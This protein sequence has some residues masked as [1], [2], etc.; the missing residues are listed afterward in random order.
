ME[1]WNSET[2]R[3]ILTLLAPMWG[4]LTL[5]PIAY[6]IEQHLKDE[7][8]RPQIRD[9]GGNFTFLYTGA[10]IAGMIA[11]TGKALGAGEILKAAV[12]KKPPIPL[13]YP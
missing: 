8:G 13:G 5:V 7:K 1:F 4:Y 6:K 12:T 3:N 9:F 10:A 2:T 11:E